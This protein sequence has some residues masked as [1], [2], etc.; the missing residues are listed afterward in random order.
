MP[1]RK[2]LM[3]TGNVHLSSFNKTNG[4]F[5]TLQCAYHRTS[6]EQNLLQVLQRPPLLLFYPTRSYL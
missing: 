5:I 1:N 2:T 3:G 4:I 6:Q